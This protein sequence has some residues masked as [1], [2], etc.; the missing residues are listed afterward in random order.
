MK[1]KRTRKIGLSLCWIGIALWL[2]LASF[3]Y[4]ILNEN[5]VQRNMQKSILKMDDEMCALID[6]GLNHEELERTKTGLTVFMNDTLVYWNRNEILP[7]LMKRKV[8]I[9]HDTICSMPSGDYY[10]KSYERG[11]TTY[12]VYKLVN[13]SY[14]IEN[15]YFENRFQTLPR[16]I[17]ANVSFNN[18][19]TE[20]ELL[21]RE[22]KILTYYQLTEHTFY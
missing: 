1:S 10:V 16:F 7:K 8:E 14:P 9:G 22:G 17:D 21:N 12:L 2:L 15:Q 4:L 13:T 18:T 5:F 20:N 3:F 6:K 11:S 19:N